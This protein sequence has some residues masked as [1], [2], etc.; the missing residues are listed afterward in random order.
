MTLPTPPG[1]YKKSTKAS[2]SGGYGFVEIWHDT[3]LAR[4][5]AIKWTA[6]ADAKQLLSE[7]RALSQRPS[8]FIVEIYD[9]V[10]DSAGNLNAIILEY[11]MGNGLE[12]IDLKAEE[13]RRL[14]LGL[15]YQM[16][17]G[18]ADLHAVGLVHRDVKPANAVCT[19]EGRLKLVD[20]GLS[21]PGTGAQTVDAKG[22][23]GYAAPEFFGTKPIPISYAM[24]VY[25]FGMVCWQ[26]L[27]GKRPKV[28][29]LGKPDS[30]RYPLPSIATKVALSAPLVKIIDQCLSWSPK[31]RPEMQTVADAFMAELTFGKHSACV[32][33]AG[34]P[35][36]SVTTE[37]GKVSSLK[38]NNG[39]LDIGYDGYKFTIKKVHGDVFVNNA[40]A[41]VGQQ[42][43]LGCLLTF[44]APG[45][46]HNREFIP[47]RQSSP[48]VVF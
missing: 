2:L 34:R 30:T 24:D 35:P 15:L 22:T 19:T 37:A 11:L 13:Q 40:P 23:M 20:F 38:K 3:S 5:V 26:K 28:G 41:M 48:E 45:L 9:V 17:Q 44:G 46:G 10:F 31:D 33:M 16:A 7:V 29:D 12:A 14:A 18:L 6:P 8:P 1:R 27:A 21:S 4:D 47:F 32:L 42:L 43:A 39:T 36:D 25:S